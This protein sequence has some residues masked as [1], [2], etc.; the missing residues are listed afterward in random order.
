MSRTNALALVCFA[1]AVVLT[2]MTAYPNELV[3]SDASPD[4]GETDGNQGTFLILSDIHFDPFADRR[5]VPKLDAAPAKEWKRIFE[6]SG[7]KRNPSYG[8]D[9]NYTLLRSAIQEAA[10]AGQNYD[11]VLLPGDYLSH[12]FIAGYR[13]CTRCSGDLEAFVAKTVTFV[14]EMISEAIPDTP[15]VG[16]FGNNDAV[17]GDYQVAPQSPLFEAV[18]RRWAELTQTERGLP[19][20]T[21]GGYYS[22]PHPTVP[23]QEIIV[24]NNIY[25]SVRYMDTCKPDGGDPGTAQMRWL[26]WTLY[27]L[28]QERKTAILLLHVPPGINAYSS[29]GC[30]DNCDYQATDFWEDE[31]SE[32]F[33]S[34][35]RTYPDVVLAA[36]SGHTHMDDFRVID[37]EQGEPLLFTRITPAVSPI[38]GNNP[39]YS[40]ADYDRTS[41]AL[42]DYEVFYLTNLEAGPPNTWDK[43]Y[44]FSEAYGLD[45]IGPGTFAALDERIFTDQHTRETFLGYYNVSNPDE[46][47]V[48]EKVWRA[49]A[50]AQ[51]EADQDDYVKCCCR[52]TQ[53]R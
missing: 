20:L 28:S 43:E 3:G 46:A 19:F 25:W 42:V 9:S 45:G 29:T 13:R 15:I 40:I 47:P 24:L 31:Y 32:S 35:V 26:E 16:A 23:E 34:L 37:D 18:Q 6:S 7:K 21:L 39:A 12:N 2:V 33:E 53:E 8:D 22:T 51:V 41:G 48:W 52:T 14:T 44:S 36:Y 17:C 30:V 10:S 27:R 5:L 50:C 1:A 49:Y 4:K 38:F 11:F